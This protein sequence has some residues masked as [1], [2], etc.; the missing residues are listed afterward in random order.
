MFLKHKKTGD[1]V[2]MLDTDALFDPC[3]SSVSG[4]FHV[5]EEMPEPASFDKSEL[6]FPS[7]E[8]LP[9][10]WIDP[11]YRSPSR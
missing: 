11:H 6:V 3:K 1:M 5:G 7:D 4:R 2:E 10:C 8:K 9:R